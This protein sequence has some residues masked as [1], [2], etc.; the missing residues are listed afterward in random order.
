MGLVRSGSLA[1]TTLRG[2]RAKVC[3]LVS[4]QTCL[5]TAES[6]DRS[7]SCEGW[8]VAKGHYSSGTSLYRWCYDDLWWAPWV[9]VAV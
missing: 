9:V 8:R 1:R 7:R 6:R 5:S 2:V 3:M 4:R